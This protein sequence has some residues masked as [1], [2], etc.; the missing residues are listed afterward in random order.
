LIGEKANLK[1]VS[2]CPPPMRIYGLDMDKPSTLSGSPLDG[3]NVTIPVA[4]TSLA[5]Q[6]MFLHTLYYVDEAPNP[7]NSLSK[8]EPRKKY[9]GASEYHLNTTFME[10]SLVKNKQNDSQPHGHGITL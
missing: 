9:P 2:A 6:N 8:P 1:E 10:R 4:L 3:Q 7:L 5:L